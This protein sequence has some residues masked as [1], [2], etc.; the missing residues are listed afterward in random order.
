MEGAATHLDPLRRAVSVS[1]EQGTT[2]VDYETL[3]YATGSATPVSHVPGVE[4][5]AY[6]L[7]SPASAKNF[8]GR[9]AEIVHGGTCVVCGN[10]LTGVEAAAEIAESFPS[11]RVVLAGR[12]VVA[13]QMNTRAR[14]YLLGVLERLGVESRT[15]VEITKVLPDAVELDDGE[16]ISSDATL[17]TTGFLASPLA[18]DAGLTVD[19]Q[20][21]I[22]VD[23]ELRSVSHPSIL[24][25]GD[26]AAIQ[27]SWGV[28]H[29]TCQSGMPSGAHA[30]DNI[31]RL[32]RGRTMKP[33]RFGYLHQPVSLG[34]HEAV[35]QFT[36]A[37]D[38]P[39]RWYLTGKSAVR[40]KE[41]ITGSPSTTYRLSR[42]FTIPMAFLARKG[43]RRARRQAAVSGKH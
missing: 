6:T 12:D 17:W 32:L 7:N 4:G 35:V 40:Y 43:P 28:I 36:K 30:A 15:G 11:V 42:R 20:R 10:G 8:A 33:F 9:L 39:S 29:G 13:P 27:Q 3:V 16:L 38:S 26:A 37:D 21:R 18:A 5:H 19:V 14:N 24:A 22:V 23:P 34:R 41:T 2:T 25:V 1:T 31:G